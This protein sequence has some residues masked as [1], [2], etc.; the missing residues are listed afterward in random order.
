M[1]TINRLKQK[2]YSFFKQVRPIAGLAIMEDALYFAVYNEV[3]SGQ[4]KILIKEFPLASQSAEDIEASLKTIKQEFK[5]NFSSAI[6]SLPPAVSYINVFEFPS[7]VN[8]QQVEES[9]KLAESTLP[10]SEA[11][12]YIDW[13]PLE[14][15]LANKK[16]AILG[17]AR[18]NIA[19]F[20]LN[21]FNNAQIT[22]VAAETYIWSL[23]RF[24]SQE[25]SETTMVIILQP[26]EAIF[27][28]Y[29]NKTPYFQFNLPREVFENKKSDFLKEI[30]SFSKRLIHFVLT[31]DSHSR[32][33][34]SVVVLGDHKLREELRSFFQNNFSEI[35]FN[36]VSVLNLESNAE[37]VGDISSG[38]EIGIL[39]ALGAAKRGVLP[40]RMDTIVSFMPVGTE[41][42]YERHRL[43]SF[44][45]FVQKFSIGF[46]GFLIMLFVG[47]L[48]M[49]KTS[50]SSV[51]KALQK[52][53]VIPIEMANVM[54]K[55]K[56]FNGQVELI[57][58]IQT[59]SPV[60]NSILNEVG[61]YQGTGITLSQ[62]S[63]DENGSVSFSGIAASR[64]A[65]TLLRDNLMKSQILEIE[66]LPLTLF[67]NKENISF[68]I[69]AKLKD[70]KFLYE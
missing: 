37:Y 3:A 48:V 63:A 60:W 64:D 36:D 5:N 34:S 32:K 35:K 53:S 19:D 23:G 40:R 65:L 56:W 49:I 47:V 11:D 14:N 66:P 69:R 44:V 17:I 68:T 15:K 20:Y 70:Q 25:D 16:E 9:M 22:P 61:Q 31:E 28:I 57:S 12:G 43:F 58:A 4:I 59:N 33:I 42:A 2:I 1:E 62:I 13:M 10:I 46:M 52:E 26:K 29:N 55:A 27:A 38:N 6:I 39:S 67:L 30:S 45:D 50:A 54:D 51:E 18:K 24:L 21:I 7:T 8:E 41:L